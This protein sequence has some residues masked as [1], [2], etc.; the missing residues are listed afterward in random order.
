M[1]TVRVPVAGGG[2][3]ITLV[4]DCEDKLPYKIQVTDSFE[5]TLKL[6]IRIQDKLN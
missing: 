3:N 2:D 4:L 6:G 5:H 1:K